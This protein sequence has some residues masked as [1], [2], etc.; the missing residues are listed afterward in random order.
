MS[1]RRKKPGRDAAPIW[2]KPAPGT[3]KPKLSREQIA[4]LALAIADAEGFDAVSMRR[5][6]TE[7]DVGTMTLYYYVRT[8]DDLIALMDDAL[9]AEVVVPA[10]RMPKG[11]RAGLREIAHR[12]RDAFL[13]HPWALRKLE[14]A[15]IGPNGMRH[16]E[17]SMAAVADLPLELPKRLEVIAIVDDYVFGSVLRGQEPGMSGD[18]KA[19]DKMI[20]FTLAQIRTGVYPNLAAMMGDD[21]PVTAFARVSRWMSADQRFERGLDAILDGVEQSLPKRAKVRP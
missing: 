18:R 4:E 5:L 3:R 13:R 21:D 7:L 19:L 9:M 14:G 11:W 10:A 16:M 2:T 20:E 12:S 17:Q 8:K 15:P 6:A 1:T